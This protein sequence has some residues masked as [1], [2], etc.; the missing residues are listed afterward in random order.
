MEEQATIQKVYEEVRKCF[1]TVSNLEALYVGK[2]DDTEYNE[3]RH[4]KEY[5]NTKIIAKGTPHLISEG[6]DY[7]IKHLK[8]DF[9]CF[10]DNKNEG[11]AGN[12]D[13]NMLYI[14]WNINYENINQVDEPE[15]FDNPYELVKD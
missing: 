5:V 10:I 4:K 6:E 14:A 12:P 7:L 3:N 15:I 9:P 2:T 13:A 11:S 8:N 1:S